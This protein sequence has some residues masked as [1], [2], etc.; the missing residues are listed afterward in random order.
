MSKERLRDRSREER[1]RSSRSSCRKIIEERKGA[2]IGN[3]IETKSR[4]TG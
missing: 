2:V 3:S 1:R 4:I